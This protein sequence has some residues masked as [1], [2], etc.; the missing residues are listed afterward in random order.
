MTADHRRDVGDRPALAAQ[1]HHVHE[2]LLR[3][4]L[5]RPLQRSV[6]GRFDQAEGLL[7]FAG[8]SGAQ[9]NLELRRSLSTKFADHLPRFSVIANSRSIL[10]IIWHQP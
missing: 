8:A 4:H 7:R 9:L 3:H 10:I 1:R 2:L 6:L 5:L